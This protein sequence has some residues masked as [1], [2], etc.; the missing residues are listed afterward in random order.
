MIRTCG[1]CTACCKTHKICELDKPVG[2]WCP[3]CIPGQGCQ[4]Y[5]SR[6]ES[7]KGF[8]CEW[9]KGDG[10]ERHRPDRVRHVLD[11]ISTGTSFTRGILQIWEAMEGGLLHP[12]VQ[13][14]TKCAL[15]NGIWVSHL[16]LSGKKKLFVPGGEVLTAELKKDVRR[17]GFEI[18]R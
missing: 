1:P 11:Y 3:H 13:G 9:L 10:E 14:W 17:E 15:V 12:R 7:C 4:I 18:V 2:K 16:Y 8:R 5:Q 6:P